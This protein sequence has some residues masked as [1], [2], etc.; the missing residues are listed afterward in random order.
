MNIDQVL[1]NL[2]NAACPIEYELA[3][4]EA[5]ETINALQAELTKARAIPD[6][7]VLVPIEPTTA[8][9][10]DGAFSLRLAIAK[11]NS[12]KS[13]KSACHSVYTAMI[14]AAQQERT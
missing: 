8:M 4:Q 12:G 6:G 13:L 11:F 14:K 2:A 7:Y 9:V 3:T 1:G 10:E 5:I